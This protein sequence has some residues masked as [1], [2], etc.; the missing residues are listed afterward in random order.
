M[1]R[2]GIIWSFIVVA[3]A[4]AWEQNP[5]GDAAVSLTVGPRAEALGRAYAALADD[6]AAIY[7]NAA[8][9]A[10]LPKTEV[11]LG[12]GVPFTEVG[13]VA[14]GDAAV[15]KPLVYSLGEEAGG[16][17]SL[18]TI[19]AALAF[20][21]VG[22]IVEADEGGPTG[23]TFADTDFCFSLAYAHTLKDN[24]AFGLAVKNVTREVGDYA[25]AGFGCDLGATFQPVASL[26]LAGVAH[27][28]IAPN[29]EL[30]QMQ[31]LAP[32]TGELAGAWRLGRV[33]AV[34]GSLAATR[35][36]LYDA[37]AGA[38]LAL[39]PAVKLRGGY[40]TGDERPRVGV[41][42]NVGGV[43]F[44]YA[45]C[46]GGPLG[47]THVGSLAFAFGG[48]TQ[49]PS[50]TGADEGYIEFTPGEEEEHAESPEETTEETP[51]ETTAPE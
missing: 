48:L 38:E 36:L 30:V 20:R 42:L 21:R 16:A 41:G 17:G 12:F 44:D 1:V 3:G 22:G 29:F 33:F 35:E 34:C 7:G 6:V 13:D 25:D 27:N 26:T 15:A 24:A 50:E 18:G 19:A 14:V 23:R 39:V 11:A 5:G 8:G 37:G 28:V 32:F 49:A 9:L 47:D 43:R 40:W 51:E 4:W 2:K 31:D 45:V 46:L 10:F